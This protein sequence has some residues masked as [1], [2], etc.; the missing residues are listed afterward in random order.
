[1][2]EFEQIYKY[3]KIGDMIIFDDYSKSKFPGLVLAV[4]EICKDYSYDRVI[5]KAS[6]DRNFVLATKK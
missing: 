4:D 1:M 5:L 3:Q 2:F 6:N